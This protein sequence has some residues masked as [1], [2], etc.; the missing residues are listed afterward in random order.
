MITKISASSEIHKFGY[1]LTLGRVVGSEEREENDGPFEDKMKRLDMQLRN[2]QAES[3]VL[4][5]AITANLK[6]ML[7]A[8][9]ES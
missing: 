5:S 3:A 6:A 1:F 8:K 2:Q 4:Y 7:F 9:P